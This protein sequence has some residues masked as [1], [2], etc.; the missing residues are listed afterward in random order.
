M[1]LSDFEYNTDH[2]LLQKYEEINF[3]LS[4]DRTVTICY[5]EGTNT[6]CLQEGCDDYYKHDLT[7]EDCITLS[8]LFKEL[9]E[10]IV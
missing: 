5:D 8:D 2:P 9:S 6:F 3:K 1:Y 4:D 7:K 10:I